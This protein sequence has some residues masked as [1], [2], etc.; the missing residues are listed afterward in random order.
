MGNT[1]FLP[2]DRPH[3]PPAGP[4]RSGPP[5]AYRFER[6]P[7]TYPPDRSSAGL[8]DPDPGQ[9]EI[10]PDGIFGAYHPE[11]LG[12]LLGHSPAGG[13]AGGK[14]QPPAQPR[15]VR[16]EGDDQVAGANDRPDPEIHTV[17]FSDHPSQEH[18]VPL[19]GRSPSRIGKQEI[20]LSP[21]LLPP[22]FPEPGKKFGK[23]IARASLALYHS[24][25]VESLQRT[26]LEKDR[27]HGKEEPV[28]AVTGKEPVGKPR[29]A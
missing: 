24:T 3:C 18:I 15:H 29:E 6:T 1:I 9:G 23:P 25:S 4:E 8:Q 19:A 12:D 26:V 7:G 5:A 13:V 10:V 21:D 16:I 11:S 20:P 27:T 22:R 28:D 14:S 2:K 17:I